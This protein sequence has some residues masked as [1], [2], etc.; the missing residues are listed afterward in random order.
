MSLVK[1]GRIGRPHGVRGEVVL[2]STD[3]TPLELHAILRFTWRGRGGATR[4]LALTAARPAHDRTLL[5]FAGVTSREQASEL[6][7]GELWAESGQLPD[8]GPEVAYQFQLVGLRVVATD[9]RE[10]GVIQDVLRTGANPVYVVRGAR[11]LLLPATP[12]VV[13]AVDV[14]AGVVTVALIAGLED[15]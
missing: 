7:L 11:E 3:L 12:E 10:L 13:R 8:P 1:V 9:G 5:T 14:A 6:T 2:D 15:L 4:D